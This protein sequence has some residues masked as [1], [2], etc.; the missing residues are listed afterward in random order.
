MKKL[1]I[2][3]LFAVL[4]LLTGCPFYGYK[5]DEGEFPPDPVN[6]SELNSAFD[7]YNMAAPVIESELYL[8]FS[9][10]R[11]NQGGDFDIVGDNFHILW[12]KDTGRLTVDDKP[13]SYNDYSYVDSLFDMINTAG[14]EFGPLSIPYNSDPISSYFS[15]TDIVI[16]STDISG[17]HDLNF[18][19]FKFP[20]ES[21][22]SDAG[23]YGGPEPLSFLN[24]E[25][26]DS[27]LSFYGPDY[28]SIDYYIDP[29][30]ITELVFCSDRNGNY[31]IFTSPVSQDSSFLGFLQSGDGSS[32]IP[33]DILNSAGDDKCPSINGN[34]LVFAS[35]HPGG[36][37]GF[38]LYYSRRSGDG[39]S[40][41]Q[42]FGERINTSS[43]EYRPVMV[44]VH[45][46][47]NDLMLF[48]SNR[49]GGQGGYDLYYVGIERM[50]D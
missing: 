34:L 33:V 10:N 39:W 46:F 8:Y 40:A 22:T 14:N 27:Y 1:I 38:D 37:G 41:P 47:R 18:V 49:E 32:V 20:S 5:Y 25:Y 44:K 11:N 35:D 24:S 26:N 30:K 42:N 2:L 3:P 21:P 48:S 15:Y 36:Y 7:D 16:Y 23:T 9:S 29:G 13:H 28:Y 50:I 43:D 4:L 31:D 12:D 45:E 6:F 19:W 17:D